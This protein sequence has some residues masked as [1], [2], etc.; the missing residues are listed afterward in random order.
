MSIVQQSDSAPEFVRS[1]KTLAVLGALGLIPFVAPPV[2]VFAGVLAPALAWAAQ[3]TY[4][5]AILGFLGGVRAAQAAMGSRADTASLMISM[6]PPLAGFAAA[7]LVARAGHGDGA[8]L[9]L[10]G[11]ALA[12][13][14]QGVWDIASPA[15][16]DWYRKLR[17]PLT[18]I[19][20]GALLLGAW[21]AE[22]VA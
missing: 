18:V 5:A 1:A 15:L 10:L 22:L 11:L 2:A 4:A 19:A 6:L 20:S 3:A 16:P 12:L 7:A 21:L 14:L 13:A 8:A 9:G 17:G